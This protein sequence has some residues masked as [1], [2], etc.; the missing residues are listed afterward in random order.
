MQRSVEDDESRARVL[1]RPE[2]RAGLSDLDSLVQTAARAWRTMRARPDVQELLGPG[3]RLHEVPFSMSV[4]DDVGN[5][6]ILRGTIDC[7]VRRRDGRVTVVEI[8]T[9][10]RR[11]RHQRQLDT[12]VEA[13]RAL[14][15]GVTV[16]GVLIY[17]E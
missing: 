7:L 11:E 13:T 8:K 16:E 1:I 12:Y 4:M 6:S 9:G 14:Y 3:E 15:P 10:Q 5:R 17:A 2:E